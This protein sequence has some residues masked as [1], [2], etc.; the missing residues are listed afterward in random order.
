MFYQHVT[1]GLSRGA[2]IIE[3]RCLDWRHTRGYYSTLPI[4]KGAR[5]A[6]AP[7]FFATFPECHNTSGVPAKVLYKN[8]VRFPIRLGVCGMRLN[9]VIL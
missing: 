2:P 6:Q 7:L 4:I 3:G 5:L 1:V 8:S 9:N